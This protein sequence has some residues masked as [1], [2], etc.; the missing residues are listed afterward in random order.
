MRLT[1]AEYLYL[2]EELVEKLGRE[3]YC[4]VACRIIHEFRRD[5]EP[6]VITNPKNKAA[7]IH[8][9]LFDGQNAIDICEIYAL[10]YLLEVIDKGKEG[11][12]A[13]P[14]EWKR[15]WKHERERGI[16]PLWL[17][18][19]EGTYESHPSAFRPFF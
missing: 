2:E 8:F 12:I 6:W 5:T 4:S 18:R 17:K 13:S 15:V 14:T 16:S 10:P 9:F 7:D 19:D 1:K 11:L 3:G